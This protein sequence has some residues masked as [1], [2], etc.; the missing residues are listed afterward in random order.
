MPDEEAIEIAFSAPEGSR[1]DK[2]VAKVNEDILGTA[3]KPHGGSFKK[4]AGQ[5]TLRW[6][7]NG[8]AG[9]KYHLKVVIN[10]KTAFD[11]DLSFDE[12]GIDNGEYPV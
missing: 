1:I 11:R 9:A 3:D 6:Q 4:A 12:W 5:W 7:I 8:K 2:L 10:G